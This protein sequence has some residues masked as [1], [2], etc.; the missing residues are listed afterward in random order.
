VE[1]GIL[2]VTDNRVAE[3]KVSIPTHAFG[4]NPEPFFA[5]L[6]I[7]SLLPGNKMLCELFVPGDSVFCGAA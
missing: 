4:Q 1:H 6:S 3:S 2:I 5:H 7:F